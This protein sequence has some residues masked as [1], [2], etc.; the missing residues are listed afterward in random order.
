[1]LT[2]IYHSFSFAWNGLKTTWREEHNFRV[3]IL[4]AVVVVFFIIFFDFSLI[5]SLFCILAIVIVLCAEIVNTAVEDLCNRVEPQHDT[6]IAKI[7]DTMAA[8]V[9]VSSF[10]AAVIGFLVFYTHFYA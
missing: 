7:K 5:E 8:F 2:K 6:I 9:L 10:G 4:I 3:E 1:M